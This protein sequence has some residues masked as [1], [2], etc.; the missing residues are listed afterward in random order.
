MIKWNESD[1][2]DVAFEIWAK[3]ESQLF[4]LFVLRVDKLLITLQPEIQ[5]LWGLHQNV[6]FPIGQKVVSKA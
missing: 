1:V 4:V 2:A 5:L 6:A 3:K